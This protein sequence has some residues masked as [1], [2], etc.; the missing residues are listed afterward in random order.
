[1][2]IQEFLSV[3]LQQILQIKVFLKSKDK[4]Q[5]FLNIIPQ[6]SSESSQITLHNYVDGSPGSASLGERTVAAPGPDP[7]LKAHQRRR[8]HVCTVR[9]DKRTHLPLVAGIKRD[10]ILWHKR[11]HFP[12]NNL[13]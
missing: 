3:S 6:L 2:E 13:G 9:S 1:M 8:S 4:K 7:S 10:A 5:L 11:N 12:I